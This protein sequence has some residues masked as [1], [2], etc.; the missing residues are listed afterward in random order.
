MVCMFNQ[1]CAYSH[2]L[3]NKEKDTHKMQQQIEDLERIIQFMADKIENLEA[4]VKGIKQ[5]EE[6]KTI[7]KDTIQTRQDEK[8]KEKEA[9]KAAVDK[10]NVVTIEATMT[11]AAATGTGTCARR[12][13][14]RM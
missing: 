14:D 4:E 2:S 9:V 7:D 3:A 1:D 11:Q 12:T 6:I 5:S 13:K 10:N 8:L